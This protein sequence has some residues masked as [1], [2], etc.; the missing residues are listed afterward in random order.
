MSTR[1]KVLGGTR[2]TAAP[3][4]CD[5]CQSGVVRRGA[6]DSDEHIYCLV[7]E[8]E[9]STR[10]VECNRYVDRTKPSLWDMRQIAWVLRT[11]STR[12]RIGFIR[13]KEWERKHEDEELLPP[14]LE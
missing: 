9:V 5:T 13:A 11:D 7:T 3:R 1:L 8:R 12:Q 10:V 14:H 4:L 2:S 6:A